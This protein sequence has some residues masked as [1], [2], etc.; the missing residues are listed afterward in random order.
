MELM[1]SLGRGVGKEDIHDDINYSKRD[2]RCCRA[3]LPSATW[4]FSWVFLFAFVLT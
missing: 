2:V 1:L 3:G 4:N